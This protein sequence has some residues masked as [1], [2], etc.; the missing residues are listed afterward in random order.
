MKKLLSMLVIGTL[1]V[2]MAGCGKTSDTGNVSKETSVTEKENSGAS[3]ETQILNMGMVLCLTGDAAVVGGAQRDGFSLGME[4]VEE[5]L[6]DSVKIDVAIEDHQGTNDLAITAINK[7]VNMDN[8]QLVVGSFSGPTQVM[9]PIA[10]E[11]EVVLMNPG[12]QADALTG[13]SDYLF[14]TVP[15]T[16]YSAEAMADFVY[17]ELGLSTASI[18]CVQ[19]GTAAAESDDFA[20]AFKEVGGTILSTEYIEAD[21]TDYSSHCAKV[22]Q[23]NP[24]FILLSCSTD[25]VSTQV[26]T[27]L[28]EIGM[29]EIAIGSLGITPSAK[30]NEGMSNPVYLA[31]VKTYMD[32]AVMSAYE[33]K[34]GSEMNVHAANMYNAA[35]ITG[36]AVSYCLDNNLELTG[37]NL[38]DALEAIGTFD[39]MGGTLA[40]DL[41]DHSSASPIEILDATNCVNEPVK[42]YFE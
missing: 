33:E 7:L 27:Q 2:S 37:K 13:L 5:S 3:G 14:T 9:A 30:F 31:N 26:L 11:N 29:T 21:E 34:Y 4:A 20:I 15:A 36:Q 1:V 38:H 18:I 24:E 28:N 8:C 6:G 17:N 25:S 32:E 12:A 39:I 22:K 35:L 10:E 41:E 40:L 42:T 16:M 23:E 19:S